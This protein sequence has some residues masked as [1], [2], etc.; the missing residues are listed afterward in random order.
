MTWSQLL[1]SVHA[2]L[3]PRVTA[4]GGTLELAQSLAEARLFLEAAPNRFRIILHWEGFADHAKARLGM[5]THQ[6]A[7]VIQQRKSLAI[8][9]GDVLTRPGPAGEPPIGDRI[10]MLRK[11]M[12][13]MMFPNGTGV[14]VAGF[15][16]SGSQWLETLQGFQAHALSWHL[17]AAQDPYQEPINLVFPT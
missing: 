16:L 3:L 10:E 17:D 12:C 6:V 11:W 7:T 4:A 2:A 5:T 9:P 1:N 14:D 8:K 13:S 15:V